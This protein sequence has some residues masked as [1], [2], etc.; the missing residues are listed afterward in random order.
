V[1]ANVAYLFVMLRLSSRGF[2]AFLCKYVLVK[3]LLVLWIYKFR[4]KATW[5]C[6][7]GLQPR[8][9]AWTWTPVH[10]ACVSVPIWARTITSARI[11][12]AVTYHYSKKQAIWNTRMKTILNNFTRN[13][14]Q[15][16]AYRTGFSEDGWFAGGH[17]A[18]YLRGDP[19]CALK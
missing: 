5:P 8:L 9:A 3:D 16:I 10:N 6:S 4:I 17:Q 2:L 1:A 15:I 12:A 13:L 19:M 14:E 18:R 11:T 7:L